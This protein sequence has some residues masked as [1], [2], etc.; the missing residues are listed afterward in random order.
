[1][2]QLD[3]SEQMAFEILDLL[4]PTLHGDFAVLYGTK[5]CY[6]PIFKS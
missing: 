3:E 2:K 4:Q 5:L 6:F 1:M